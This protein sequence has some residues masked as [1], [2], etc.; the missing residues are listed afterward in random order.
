MKNKEM[1]LDIMRRQG[2][3]DALELRS[4]AK[5]LSGTELIA[6]EA[7]APMFDPKKD[8]SSWPVGAPVADGGQVW[9]LLQPYNAAHYS[10]RPADLRAL[11]G[12]AHTKDPQQAK[13]WVAPLG[14]SGLYAVDEVCIHEGRVW[15]NRRANNEYPPGTIGAKEFWEMIRE[16]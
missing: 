8:Y 2:R 13:P 5:D 14:T 1:I 4:V 10:G 9:T 3:A 11:W 7:Q 6:R 12:L 15:R 16:V